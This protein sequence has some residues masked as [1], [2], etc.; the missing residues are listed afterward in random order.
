M[1]GGRIYIFVRIDGGSNNLRHSALR[2]DLKANMKTCHEVMPRASVHGTRWTETIASAET[3]HQA[4]PSSPVFTSLQSDVV[5]SA[6]LQPTN[7]CHE[8]SPLVAL[9]QSLLR[10]CIA[11]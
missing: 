5:A 4:V 1:A 6:E 9:H 3:C 7:T 11:R 10:I 8:P 2:S